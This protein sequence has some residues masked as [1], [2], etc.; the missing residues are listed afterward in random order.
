LIR[1]SIRASSRGDEVIV[2][3]AKAGIQLNALN[4]P[5]WTPTF[6]GVTTVTSGV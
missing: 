2:I 6:V 4:A 1:E 3:P 5:S